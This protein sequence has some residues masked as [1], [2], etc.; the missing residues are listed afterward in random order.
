MS[1]TKKSKPKSRK[2]SKKIFVDVKDVSKSYKMGEVEV[3]ALRNVSLSFNEGEIVS[4]VGPS[5]SGK[6][7]LLNVIGALDYVIK[8][9]FCMT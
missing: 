7:T 6:T 8:K 1:D 2:K 9:S 5:G 3:Q 4:I